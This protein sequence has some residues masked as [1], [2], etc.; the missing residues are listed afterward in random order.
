MSSE[1]VAPPAEDTLA[2]STASPSRGG[3]FFRPPQTA[4]SKPDDY[5]ML[6]D[7]F[8]AGTELTQALRLL[9]QWL[10]DPYRASDA[11]AKRL[12]R[13]HG[14]FAIVC[15][16]VGTFVVLFA[17]AQLAALA[18]KSVSHDPAWAAAIDPLSDFAKRG[19]LIG[20]VLCVIAVVAGLYVS[21]QKGWL[22][23]RHKAECIR[24]L[25]FRALAS[26]ALW[27]N[28]HDG[29][30]KD[31][32]QRVAFAVALTN[33]QLK[34]RAHGDPGPIEPPALDECR[35]DPTV[36]L[37]LAGYYLDKRIR[38]QRE[39]FADR[40]GRY[41]R[42]EWWLYWL[43]LGCFFG[44]IGA[45]FGHFAFE[46][47]AAHETSIVFL[48]VAA[49]LPVIG[50]GVRTYRQAHEYGRSAAIFHAKANAMDEYE[51]RLGVLKMTSPDDAPELLRL[52][53][54]CEDFLEAEQREWLRLMLE[55]EWFG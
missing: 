9:G 23:E 28:D 45:A 20:L 27:C 13:T 30:G 26:P 24:L 52:M 55:L 36:Q 6:D 40:S 7:G 47:W 54:D 39:F 49:A 25:K 5:D 4:M 33:R 51:K 14:M 1:H 32:G 31:I 12:R 2:R 37:E 3:Q 43:P 44:S 46:W 17:I 19:E 53:I 35:I 16:G 18:M 11:A 42:A 38:H 10:V 29:W 21:S 15:A 34:G 50:A 48:A 8:V 41:E 22:R